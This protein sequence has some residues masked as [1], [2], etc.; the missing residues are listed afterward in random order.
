MLKQTQDFLWQFSF[1]FLNQKEEREEKQI[2]RISAIVAVT[3][4]WCNY[5]SSFMTIEDETEKARTRFRCEE[6]R[7]KKT[8]VKRRQWNKQISF[9]FV[10]VLE[11][12]W[13]IR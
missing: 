11:V 10:D 2:R 4:F 12:G 9:W 7:K 13:F 5:S 3:V 8:N 1:L 6:K